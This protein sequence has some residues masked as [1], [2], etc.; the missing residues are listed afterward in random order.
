MSETYYVIHNS[1]GDTYVDAYDEADFEAWMFEIFEIYHDHLGEVRVIFL[2]EPL[3]FSTDSWRHEAKKKYSLNESPI[4]YFVIRG[5]PVQP[6]NI[7]SHS[8]EEIAE[9]LEET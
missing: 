5:A 3:G 2:N 7:Q 1:D 8:W 6:R 9:G 4:V